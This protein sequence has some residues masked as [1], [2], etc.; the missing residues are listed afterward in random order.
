MPKRTNMYK[1]SI[2]TINY[3]N[4]EGLKRTVE[5]VLNQTW[6]E[7]EY[8]VIDGGSTDGNK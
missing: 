8:I 5:S 1:L 2:I 6:Q 3:N 7:F 4:L